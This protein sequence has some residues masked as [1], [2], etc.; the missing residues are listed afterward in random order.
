MTEADRLRAVAAELRRLA[1]Q[2]FDTIHLLNLADQCDNAAL[3]TPPPP[4]PAPDPPPVPVPLHRVLFGATYSNP[5]LPAV[6]NYRVQ[7]VPVFGWGSTEA[8]LDGRITEMQAAEYR[9]L[10]ACNAPPQ[11]RGPPSDQWGG[12]NDRVLSQ[13]HQA[14]ANYVGDIIRRNNKFGLKRRITHVQ[15]WNEAKG[16]YNGAENRWNYEEL[17]DLQN[18]LYDAIKLADPGVLCGAPYVAFSKDLPGTGS[19]RASLGSLNGPWGD[20]DQRDY[21]LLEYSFKFGK[22]DFICVDANLGCRPWKLDG[23]L[24]DPPGGLAA[25]G[26]FATVAW[27]IRSK[28]GNDVPIWWSEIYPYIGGQSLWTQVF[29]SLQA[30]PGEHV[31]LWWAEAAFPPPPIV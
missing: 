23:T 11:F 12:L 31:L 6:H 27:W 25:V 10:T 19:D 3:G 20:S 8:N 2:G 13:F 28:V 22:K 14:Y 15:L 29:D 17:I 1:A 16:Y 24:N 30:V 21:D 9:V 4:A 5:T 7:A 18:K 26:Y